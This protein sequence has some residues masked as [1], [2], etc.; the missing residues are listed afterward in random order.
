MNIGM[1]FLHNM[2]NGGCPAWIYD[3]RFESFTDAEK[4]AID[5]AFSA[6]VAYE[7]DGGFN[8][9]QISKHVFSDGSAE[10]W[11][12]RFTWDV[13]IWCCRS[14]EEISE[15]LANYYKS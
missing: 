6:H 1:L 8:E 15:K 13:G 5:V 4:K 2:R 14:V 3:P 11:V 7:Q 10:Y 9:W 12:K